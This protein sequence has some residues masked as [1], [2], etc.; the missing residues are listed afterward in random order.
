MRKSIV[1]GIAIVVIVVIAAVVYYLGIGVPRAPIKDT[2]EV[3]TFQ[4]LTGIDAANGI[5]IAWILQKAVHDVNEKGGVYVAEYGRRLPVRLT[6]L[7]DAS[8]PAVAAEATEK[9][10]KYYHVDFIIG[11]HDTKINTAAMEIAKK[12]N[13]LFITSF[14]WGFDFKAV[15][16]PLGLC[17]FTNPDVIMRMWYDILVNAKAP[18]TLAI[19]LEDNYDGR[20]VGEALKQLAKE[21]GFT[22]PVE[23]YYQPGV[24]EF[25][26]IIAKLK[27][28]N[29][30]HVFFHGFTIDLAAFV[31]QTKEMK[32]NWKFL[33]AIKGGW[34][35][36][37]YKIAGRDSDYVVSDGFFHGSFPYPGAR[38]IWEAFKSS[39][40]KFSVG[41]PLYY[42][43]PQVL[44]QAIE[45]AGTLKAEK[46]VETVK[47]EGPWLTIMGPLTFDEDGFAAI[48]TIALQ[49]YNGELYPVHPPQLAAKELVYPAPPWDQRG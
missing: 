30:E 11:G 45:K 48:S 31:K 4:S 40:G 8:N 13:V 12:Y 34:P 32:Y 3:G 15:K 29:A 1:I 36:E 27:A 25:S 22:I 6:L 35:I 46:I 10:V 18:K 37:F 20:A 7:D 19:I 9:L 26:S 49:W 43:A 42:S 5:E 38:E 28:A 24:C 21:Y 14:T 47:K 16:H 39:F 44:F 41:S 17:I 2:I 23:D 33:C